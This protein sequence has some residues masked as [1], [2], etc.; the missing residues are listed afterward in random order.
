MVK[1]GASLGQAMFHVEQGIFHSRAVVPR[2]TSCNIANALL[3]F[4]LRG[5]AWPELSL[6]LIKKA[7]SEKPPPL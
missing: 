6:L 7:A 4:C 3:N 5:S 2:E 1:E